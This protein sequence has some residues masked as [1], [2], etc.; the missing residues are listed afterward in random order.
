MADD[1]AKKRTFRQVSAESCLM[2]GG[3]LSSLPFSASLVVE[4]LQFA[5]T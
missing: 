1:G 3:G 2:A 4:Q 5:I